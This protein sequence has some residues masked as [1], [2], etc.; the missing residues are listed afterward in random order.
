MLLTGPPPKGV[1]A[2]YFIWILLTV[3]LM[4]Y[5]YQTLENLKEA[6][7]RSKFSLKSVSKL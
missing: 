5:V 3:T 2:F 4:V 1:A 6:F 7:R